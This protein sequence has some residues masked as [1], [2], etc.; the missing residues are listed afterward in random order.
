MLSSLH[1]LLNQ[2]WSTLHLQTCTLLSLLEAWKIGHFFAVV[3]CVKFGIF[4]YIFLS[5]RINPGITFVVLLFHTFT[6]GVSKSCGN[7]SF[8]SRCL[9]WS[10]NFAHPSN[11][12]NSAQMMMRKHWNQT[13]HLSVWFFFFKWLINFSFYW[14]WTISVFHTLKSFILIETMFLREQ[15][16]NQTCFWQHLATSNDVIYV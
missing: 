8:F 2:C 7:S 9:C 10:N 1:Q 13:L 6:G 16:I 14:S 11:K 5:F 4:E 12:L 15:F 3:I